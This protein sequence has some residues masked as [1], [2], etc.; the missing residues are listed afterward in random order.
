MVWLYRWVPFSSSI[1]PASFGGRRS[2]RRGKFPQPT[3]WVKLGSK[4]EQP[5]GNNTVMMQP[6][7]FQYRG[8]SLDTSIN[9]SSK[10]HK[11]KGKISE[12]F[13]PDTSNEKLNQLICRVTGFFFLRSWLIFS[14]FKKSSEDLPH[15]I[16]VPATSSSASVPNVVYVIGEC[17][18][19]CWNILTT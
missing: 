9:I 18:N 15:P 13:L 17:F 12:V 16:Y 5:K 8:V 4:I 6:R 11:R 3:I 7:I 2:C 1:Q 14:F 19:Y 10:T